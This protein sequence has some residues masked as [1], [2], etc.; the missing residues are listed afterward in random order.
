MLLIEQR[1]AVDAAATEQLR[2]PFESR[3]KSRLRTRLASG[4]ECGLFL[5]RGGVLRGGDK[6]LG[7]DGRVV[8]VVAASELLL[9]AVS[10]DPLQL[11]R[12]AYHLG[13]RHVAVQLLPGRLRFA[14]DHVLGEMVRGL[15]LPVDSIETPF[16]PESG[17][18]GAHG[19]HGHSTDGEGRGARIHDH[20]AAG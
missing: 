4:E 12:A 17:A 10:N 18:Y 16:E 15:G 1:A 7:Q 5:E 8:A 2:L 19:G 9:E 3:C 13:N 11:A 20:F 14:Q 6:L